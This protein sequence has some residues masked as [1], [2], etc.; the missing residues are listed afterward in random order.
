MAF[1]YVQAFGTIV[2]G[3]FESEEEMM[4][5]HLNNFEHGDLLSI[6][7]DKESAE[8]EA[9]QNMAEREKEQDYLEDI[10]YFYSK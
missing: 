1:Y 5:F 8:R 9:K 3:P 4:S 7:E 10:D 6:H 2:Y